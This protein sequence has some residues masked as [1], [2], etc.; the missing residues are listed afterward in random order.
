MSRRSCPATFGGERRPSARA[1][2]EA[3]ALRLPR[4]S[5]SS[6][7]KVLLALA[8]SLVI[9]AAVLSASRMRPSHRW[10][11]SVPPA[12]PAVVTG[13]SRDHAPHGQPRQ[14][15]NVIVFTLFTPGFHPAE[16]TVP[17]GRYLLAV[18]NQSGLEEIELRL[19][20]EAGQSLKEKQTRRG[21]QVWK[22]VIDFKPGS[23][24]VTEAGRPEWT[25]HII[26]TD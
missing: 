23:Y 21:R 18:E 14:Q 11:V 17:K 19:R 3:L 12:V 20:R 10:D 22:E 24:V 7:K 4:I 16:V 9:G 6:S 5:L 25:C 26:I 13:L 8:L 2:E 1:L 15:N